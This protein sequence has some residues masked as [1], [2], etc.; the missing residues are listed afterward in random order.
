[1]RHQGD[2]LDC[3]GCPETPSD[4]LDEYNV[5]GIKQG[6]Q[7]ETTA[8]FTRV[9]HQGTATAP[10]TT[11]ITTSLT[12][13]NNPHKKASKSTTHDGGKTGTTIPVN[14]ASSVTTSTQSVLNIPKSEAVEVSFRYP[15][16]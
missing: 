8:L 3:P 6:I 9:N 4:Q 10:T 5:K 11:F 15:P 16:S 14:I 2:V 1:M 12:S 13:S 7:L